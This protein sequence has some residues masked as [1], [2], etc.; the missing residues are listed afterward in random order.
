MSKNKS[1]KTYNVNKFSLQYDILDIQIDKNNYLI[2]FLNII[3]YYILLNKASQSSLKF[4]DKLIS[5]KDLYLKKFK[6]NGFFK[7]MILSNRKIF[8]QLFLFNDLFIVFINED[9]YIFY[10]NNNDLNNIFTTILNY[11][12]DDY[13]DIKESLKDKIKNKIKNTKNVLDNLNSC[14]ICSNLEN[15]LKSVCNNCLNNKNNENVKYLTGDENNI[16]YLFN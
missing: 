12:S 11:C 3:K 4:I 6:D 16:E 7:N 15:K 5:N 13:D 1:L 14:N 10:N 2:T 9:R 8:I